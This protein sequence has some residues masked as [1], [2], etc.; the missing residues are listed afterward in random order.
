MSKVEFVR[1]E[2]EKSRSDFCGRIQSFQNAEQAIYE[3]I[4]AGWKYHGFIPFEVRQHYGELLTIS[5]IF[6]KE[7]EE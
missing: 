1:V 2:S 6:E 5:L 7:D 4:Q 3:R